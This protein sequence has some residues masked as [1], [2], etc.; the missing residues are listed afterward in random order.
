MFTSI[1]LFLVTQSHAGLKEEFVRYLMSRQLD[2]EFTIQE[3]NLSTV[4]DEAFDWQGR[5]CLNRFVSMGSLELEI[6]DFKLDLITDGSIRVNT[7]LKNIRTNPYGYF[8]SDYT[9]CRT[10]RY[11]RDIAISDATVEGIVTFEDSANGDL[12]PHL[13]VTRSE[14][15]RLH[16]S[17]YLPDSVERFLTKKINFAINKVWA[18]KWGEVMNRRISLFLEKKFR[19]NTTPVASK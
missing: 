19:E 11:K 7:V 5:L 10:I 17:R 16:F 18:S 4:Y 2:Q 3:R 14:L 13:K 6:D 9:L 12:I 8:R 15:G 1:L